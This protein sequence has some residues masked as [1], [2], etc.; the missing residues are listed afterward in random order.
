VVRARSVGRWGV[1]KKPVVKPGLP[2]TRPR[3]ARTSHRS[4]RQCIGLFWASSSV[5][6]AEASR[7][8][9]GRCATTRPRHLHKV[10]QSLRGSKRS[11]R[12]IAI[13]NPRIINLFQRVQV[14]GVPHAKTRSPKPISPPC[15]KCGEQYAKKKA[16]ERRPQARSSG[17]SLDTSG[18]RGRARPEARIKFVGWSFVPYKTRYNATGHTGRRTADQ[19]QPTLIMP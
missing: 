6:A 11:A 4:R 19:R 5:L 9:Y 7:S 18:R 14:F 16:H 8:P 13:L 2:E 17:P 10:T 15:L 3:Q 12:R 1:P